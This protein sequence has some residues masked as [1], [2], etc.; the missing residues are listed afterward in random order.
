MPTVRRFIGRIIEDNR[1]ENHPRGGSASIMR[2][3]THWLDFGAVPVL[4]N[5]GNSTTTPVT[6]AAILL[7]KLEP[8]ADDFLYSIKGK[9]GR[10][11]ASSTPERLRIEDVPEDLIAF[12]TPR[13]IEGEQLIF[14]PREHVRETGRVSVYTGTPI[15]ERFLL[16]IDRTV[17]NRGAL[18]PVAHERQI[19]RR[20][21]LNVIREKA[22][23]A[24]S[25]YF[26]KSLFRVRTGDEDIE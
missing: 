23:H 18:A 17:R 8:R 21:E 6:Q 9:R 12:F 3:A 16:N 19:R 10:A 5:P 7:E 26:F 24:L 1:T 11:E 25:P 14:A 13:S 20:V 15:P 4:I 2:M 22:N